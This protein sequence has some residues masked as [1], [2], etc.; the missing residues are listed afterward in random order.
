MRVQALAPPTVGP[1]RMLVHVGLR[2]QA[3]FPSGPAGEPWRR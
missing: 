3:L 1:S 2:W